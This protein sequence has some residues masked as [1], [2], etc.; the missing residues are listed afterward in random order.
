MQLAPSQGNRDQN[1][2]AD[3]LTQ[4]DI[5]GF[6]PSLKFHVEPSLP[7]LHG[8]S[9]FWKTMFLTSDCA[10]PLTR[11]GCPLRLWLLPARFLWDGTGVR[12]LDGA[13][14]Q[15]PCKKW[16]LHGVLFWCL[17]FSCRYTVSEQVMRGN[18]ANNN[19]VFKS[20]SPVLKPICAATRFQ[21]ELSTRKPDNHLGLE[22]NRCVMPDPRCRCSNRQA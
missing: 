19:G 10:H 14:I 7:T 16:R 4:P 9:L 3:E 12:L 2:R 15:P 8:S 11:A 13:H 21:T 20:G 17:P 5:Q 6:T 22:S 1:T 18:D